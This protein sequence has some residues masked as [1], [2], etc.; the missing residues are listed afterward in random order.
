[1]RSAE[2]RP[3][4]VDTAAEGASAGPAT[5]AARHLRAAFPFGGLVP[6]DGRLLLR[7][8]IVNQGGPGFFRRTGTKKSR[9]GAEAEDR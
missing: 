3:L 5:D 2:F 1:M 4:I 8:W 7:V 9:S 6:W